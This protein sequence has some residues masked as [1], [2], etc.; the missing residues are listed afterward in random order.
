MKKVAFFVD[1]FNLYHAI[2]STFTHHR[3]KWLNL[4][5]L[6]QH[7]IQNDEEIKSILYFTA[8]STWDE[9]KL[10][11][12]KAY[13]RA[14]SSKGVDIV[15][16]Q[17]QEV[18]KRFL[19]EKMEVKDVVPPEA[20]LPKEFKFS[21]YEEKKTDVNIAVKLIEFASHGAF[22]TFYIISADSDFVPALNYIHKY[23]RNIRLVNIL[24]IKARG[25]KLA[26][27]CDDQ[28]EMTEEHL[29]NSLLEYEVKQGADRILIPERYK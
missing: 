15:L 18:R 3:Y 28:I 25:I 1:G 24:P 16:G 6:S 23:H 29:Q 8:Y 21:T 5:Q 11:R 12:H 7:L 22:D 14:L 10:L 9:S 26:Q 27:V 20:I 19:K 2:D 17:F 4:R 13:V